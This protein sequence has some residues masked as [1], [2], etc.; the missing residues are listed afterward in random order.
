M[1]KVMRFEYDVGL[2]RIVV[3]YLRLFMEAA[4]DAV[5]TVLANHGETFGFHKFLDRRAD[6]AQVDAASPF[7]APYRLS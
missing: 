6:G 7:S 4:A 2:R 1:V 3:Q 5:A